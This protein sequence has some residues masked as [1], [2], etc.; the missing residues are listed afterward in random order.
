MKRAIFLFTAVMMIH[1]CQKVENKAVDRVPI[2]FETYVGIP[3]ITRAEDENGLDFIKLN[4]LGVWALESSEPIASGTPTESLK[5]EEV[6]WRTT[7]TG[8]YW[9]YDNLI[10]W[11]GSN[12]MS[13]YAYAPYERVD[14]TAEDPGAGRIIYP[15]NDGTPK[16]KLSLSNIRGWDHVD[17]LVSEP[18]LNKTQ[19]TEAVG[20]VILA[21][22]H[23]LCRI[24]F[25]ARTLT[26]AAEIKIQTIELG[27]AEIQFKNT[28]TMEM[29]SLE[30]ATW[31]FTADATTNSYNLTRLSVASPDRHNT[32]VKPIVLTDEYQTV[33][34]NPLIPIPQ[35]FENGL[36]FTISYLDNTMEEEQKPKTLTGTIPAL[37]FE[38]GKQYTIRFTVTSS[39]VIMFD[40]VVNPWVTDTDGNI[41]VI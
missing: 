7:K 39:D 11:P 40:V 19:N 27:D 13:F 2:D 9:G 18:L 32:A 29:S 20:P 10:Y 4:G 35:S 3:A 14:Y 38:K 1:S 8:D 33:T 22:S 6:T 30:T 21:F 41:D 28:A 16:I 31:S 23:A 24:A 37:T 15:Y 17:L 34:E 12:Y 26:P 5:N 25:Q 36:P